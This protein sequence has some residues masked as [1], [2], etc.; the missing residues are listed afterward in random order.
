MYPGY[1]FFKMFKSTY[2]RAHKDCKYI[3]VNAIKG[4][5]ISNELFVK[6]IYDHD[7]NYTIPVIV[8]SLYDKQN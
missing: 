1:L 4:M 7:E 8:T 6:M 2:E 5:K 3:Y